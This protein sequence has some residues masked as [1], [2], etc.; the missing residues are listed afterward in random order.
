MCRYR[1]ILVYRFEFNNLIIYLCIYILINYCY[2]FFEQKLLLQ[3]N[4][5]N[6]KA[7]IKHRHR[8]NSGPSYIGL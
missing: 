4:L 2:N 3:I 5:I 7:H 1:C 8:P 6:T